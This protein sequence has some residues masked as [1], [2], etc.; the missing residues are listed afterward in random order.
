MEW[1]ALSE[2]QGLQGVVRGESHFAQVTWL[3]GPLAD[4]AFTSKMGKET[5]SWIASESLLNLSH[6][7]RKHTMLKYALTEEITCQSFDA[8][9]HTKMAMP[10]LQFKVWV[11][12]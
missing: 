9:A 4:H 1:N 5:K 2:S 7:L 12:L 10:R 6:M 3:G 11:T 8:L